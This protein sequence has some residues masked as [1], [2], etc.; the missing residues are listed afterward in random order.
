MAPVSI[1]E[2]VSVIDQL[3]DSFDAKSDVDQLHDIHNLQ[4]VIVTHCDSSED[5]IKSIIKGE[6]AATP[7][8]VTRPQ[9]PALSIA[10]STRLCCIRLILR[11]RLEGSLYNAE[12][13]KEA[14]QVEQAATPREPAGAHSQRVQALRAAVREAQENVASMTRDARY[15]S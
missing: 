9:P 12:L 5:H 8:P 6:L 14:R 7:L 10:P 11:L 2:H 15:G 3:K 4:E 1:S 13:L